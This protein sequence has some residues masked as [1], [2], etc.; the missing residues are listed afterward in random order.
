MYRDYTGTFGGPY[1][2]LFGVCDQKPP[3]LPDGTAS[4]DTGP[5]ILKDGLEDSTLRI[6]NSKVVSAVGLSDVAK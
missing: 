6:Q 2:G 5:E 4:G 1:S 3:Y